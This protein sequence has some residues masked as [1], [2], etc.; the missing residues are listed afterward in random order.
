MA[1]ANGIKIVGEEPYAENLHVRFCEGQADSNHSHYD[2]L[3]QYKMKERE[4][5]A[6]STRLLRH[7]KNSKHYD[8]N[9]TGD[10]RKSGSGFGTIRNFYVNCYD[11]ILKTN[12][13]TKKDSF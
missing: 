5:R 13:I 3:T 8:E 6:L 11:A 2:I 7:V 10:K 12:S 1:L 9:R 4:C